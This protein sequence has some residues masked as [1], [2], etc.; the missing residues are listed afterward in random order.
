MLSGRDVAPPTAISSWAEIS[1]G[2]LKSELKDTPG[3]KVNTRC[4]DI[5]V[6]S[7]ASFYTCRVFWSCEAQLN[8]VRVGR[9]FLFWGPWVRGEGEGEAVRLERGD[10]RG[11]GEHQMLGEGLEAEVHPAGWLLQ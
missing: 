11:R 8:G 10:G 3:N 9:V 7:V 1:S 2:G 4:C 6:V 5:L